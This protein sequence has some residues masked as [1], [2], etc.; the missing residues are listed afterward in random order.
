MAKKIFRAE[1]KYRRPEAYCLLILFSILLIYKIVVSL[2]AGPSANALS[3]GEMIGLTAFFALGWYVMLT[4]KMGIRVS[5]KSLKVRYN[6]LFNGRQKFSRSEVDYL[7]FVQVPEAALWNGM[8][9]HFDTDTN[10]YGMGDNAG[11]RIVLNSGKEI[12][13]FS[14]RLFNSREHITECL[15]DAGWEVK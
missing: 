14:R 15:N 5:S 6:Y 13:V 9:V 11:I 4:Y 2:G 3:I 1:Q 12:F 7:E 10:M 8:H